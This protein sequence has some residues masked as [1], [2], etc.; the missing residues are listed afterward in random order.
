MMMNREDRFALDTQPGDLERHGQR[1][2]I[3]HSEY[4]LFPARTLVPSV[5]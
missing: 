1:H 4:T 2:D 3:R 5:S